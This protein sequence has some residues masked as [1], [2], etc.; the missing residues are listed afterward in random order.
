M[1]ALR[2]LYRWLTECPRYPDSDSGS[3][4]T[5]TTTESP[6]KANLKKAVKLC[7]AILRAREAYHHYWHRTQRWGSFDDMF[8]LPRSAS[9]I[10]KLNALATAEAKA[11][12][13]WNAWMQANVPFSLPPR[14]EWPEDF[15][16]WIT[17][18]L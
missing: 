13:A 5:F 4:C 12:A 10:A 2:R 16:E 15:D 11:V 8:P 14:S 18:L 17:P 7:R 1:N 9:E 3:E 6:A